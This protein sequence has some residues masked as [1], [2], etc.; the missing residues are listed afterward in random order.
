M[1]NYL[2]SNR[3]QDFADG[4]SI[5]RFLGGKVVNLEV[6]EI[7]R[8]TSL[9]SVVII[10]GWDSEISRHARVR[11]EKQL[12]DSGAALYN[13]AGLEYTWSYPAPWQHDG[14][15]PGSAI[16]DEAAQVIKGVGLDV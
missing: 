6:I 5:G 15:E 3:G 7:P 9:D 12:H 4:F 16:L 11:W 14:N 2:L 10:G 1:T 13:G 8:V